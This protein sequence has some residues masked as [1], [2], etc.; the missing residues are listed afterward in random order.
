MNIEAARN[1]LRLDGTDNDTI[2]QPL[3]DAMPSYIE[4]TTGV[5]STRQQ[6]DDTVKD[7]VTALEG[8]LLQIWYNPEQRDV[9]KLETITQSLIKTLGFMKE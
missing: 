8:F 7:I 9:E 1:K 2:I 6:N 3:L 5:T 4:Q